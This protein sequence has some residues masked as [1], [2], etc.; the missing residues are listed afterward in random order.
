MISGIYKKQSQKAFLK[1]FFLLT[2][3]KTT[4]WT[5]NVQFYGH[6]WFSGVRGH[7]PREIKKK[8]WSEIAL[9][10]AFLRTNFTEKEQASWMVKIHFWFLLFYGSISMHSG[11][12]KRESCQCHPSAHHCRPVSRKH[13]AFLSIEADL[14]SSVTRIPLFIECY[15]TCIRRIVVCQKF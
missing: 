14:H 12:K 8:Q 1:S 9:A 7:A 5:I 13:P 6:F 11:L 2:N 4:F 10:P 15:K 3:D